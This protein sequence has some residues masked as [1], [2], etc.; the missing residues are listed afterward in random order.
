M[1]HEALSARDFVVTWGHWAQQ[2][3]Y[4][5]RLFIA[6]MPNVF[7]SVLK[8]GTSACAVSW[9]VRIY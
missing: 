8:A 5:R 4:A 2:V 6:L 1:R 3:T 9:Q 7:T